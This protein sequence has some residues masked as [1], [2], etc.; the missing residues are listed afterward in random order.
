MKSYL[1]LDSTYRNRL[2]YPNP[3]D[4]EIPFQLVNSFVLNP[5]LFTSTNPISI[6]Y[7]DYNFQWTNYDTP[8]NRF[9]M[10]VVVS[11]TPNAPIIDD[12]IDTILG[13]VNN[14]YIYT[15]LPSAS[16]LLKGMEFIF[17]SDSSVIY[18]ITS[19]DPYTR[20]VFLDGAISNFTLP[21]VY[22]I[23]NS[24]TTQEIAIQGDFLSRSS[25]VYLDYPL[26][27]YDMTINEI[28]SVKQ[29]IEID[30]RFVLT[31]PFSPAWSITDAYMVLSRQLPLNTGTIQLLP[32]NKYYIYTIL[33]YR[34]TEAG[35]AYAPNSIVYAVSQGMAATT[36]ALQFRILEVSAHGGI[37]RM[38]IVN[39]GSM[40]YI[41]NTKCRLLQPDLMTGSAELI[42]DSTA[43]AFSVTLNRPFDSSLVNSYFLP[44]LLSNQFNTT[45]GTVR[46]SGNSTIPLRPTYREYTPLELQYQPPYY[47]Y[48]GSMDLYTSQILNG[49]SGIQNIIPIDAN[50]GYILVQPYPLDRISRFDAIPSPLPPQLHG[51][52]NFM[53]IPFTREGVVGLNF[54]GT[55]LTQSQ[56][57]CYQMTVMTLILPNL[58]IDVGAGPL[59]SALPYVFL[60]ISNVTAGRNKSVLYSNNPYTSSVTFVC[61]ISDVN[62]PVRTKFIKISSDGSSQTIK[63][64][65]VDTLRLR[66]SL[67][68][69]ETF[70]TEKS[71]YLIPNEPD[72]R[73]QIHA[74]I[75]LLRL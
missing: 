8:D 56:V 31:E 3:A 4:F 61:S 14:P 34:I 71:D 70:I 12:T 60:E 16:N 22:A 24:S 51:C 33:Q 2:L 75:E 35:T 39:V 41:K 53:V 23:Y 48:S 52:L 66:I 73:L 58:T 20:T 50:T 49:V 21:A 72:P 40:D 62:D 46:I 15:S 45:D 74:V 57:S 19:Y 36:D 27:L 18:K 32:N 67:P 47:N 44:F 69:G 13:I 5:T 1:L 59:T 29:F 63:F 9:I 30:N 7:P 54:T 43:L 64:S 11:G 37:K 65:P 42:I 28:K 25:V 55:Q 68:G 26:Y 10:G 38:E 6:P 17:N